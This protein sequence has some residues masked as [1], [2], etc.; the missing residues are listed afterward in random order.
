MDASGCERR[1]RRYPA[2]TVEPQKAC[3]WGDAGRCVLKVLKGMLESRGDRGRRKGLGNLEETSWPA[4]T[5]GWEP[6]VAG[7]GVG[8][9]VATVPRP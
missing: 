5:R 9:N 4:R 8:R 3:H 2:S 6:R 1:L 7:S